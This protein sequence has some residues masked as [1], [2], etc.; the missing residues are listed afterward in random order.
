MA[1]FHLWTLPCS[2][3]IVNRT[4]TSWTPLRRRRRIPP[5]GPC[6]VR[7]TGNVLRLPLVG[8][9]GPLSI[10]PLASLLPAETV[11]L[12]PVQ[13]RGLERRSRPEGIGSGNVLPSDVPPYKLQLLFLRHSC[14]IG[15]LWIALPVNAGIHR[16][17]SSIWFKIWGT[18]QKGEIK[19]QAINLKE[20]SR[21]II[22]HQLKL[23][24]RTGYL[25]EFVHAKQMWFV[26]DCGGEIGN[27]AQ[28]TKRLTERKGLSH[29]E[30]LS[31]DADWVG[32]AG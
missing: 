20:K 19:E 10:L 15:L 29:R 5:R 3:R 32:C 12:H 24:N 8:F 13:Q 30:P 16:K 18:L 11:S 26:M 17:P 23:V 6:S 14:H 21:Q 31:P 27:A 9:A 1:S 2:F 25:K 22:I 28:H 4:G 7:P